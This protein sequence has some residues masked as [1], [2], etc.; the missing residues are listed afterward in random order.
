MKL[1]E[2]RH[3]PPPTLM[4]ELDELDDVDSLQAEMK[5]LASLANHLKKEVRRMKIER[6]CY[7]LLIVL[8]IFFI[9]YFMVKCNVSDEQKFLSLP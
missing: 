1:L 7:R 3:Q 6:K 4:D 2:D 8:L 9:A 5:A